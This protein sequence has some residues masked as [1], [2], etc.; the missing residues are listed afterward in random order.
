MTIERQ[1]QTYAAALVT[2]NGKQTTN[3]R[4]LAIEMNSRNVEMQYQFK[5]Q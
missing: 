4:W 5:Q 3:M 1:H 2:K